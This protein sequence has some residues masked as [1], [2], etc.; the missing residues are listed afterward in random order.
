MSVK[1]FVCFGEVLMDQFPTG[2]TIGGSPLNVA[3]WL[4][5]MDQNVSM[6]SGIGADEDGKLL[7]NYLAHN[8]INTEHVN[9][10]KHLPTGVV[11]VCIDF[12]GSAKYKIPHPVAWDRIPLQEK[13]IELVK[14]SDAF[15]YS[16]LPARDEVNFSTIMQLLESSNYNILDTNLR[17]PHYTEKVLTSFCEAADFIKFNDEELFEIAKIYG[18]KHRSIE[19]NL[20]FLQN[21][22]GAETI[23][24]TK[25]KY[26]AVVLHNGELTYFSGY[27]AD[28]V[29]TVGAGDSFLA[30]FISK[31]LNG[32]DVISSLKFA[33]GVGAFVASN[34][35]ANPDI[36]N[37]ELEEFIKKL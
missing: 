7:M 26:G 19:D 11:E 37:G 9:E 36:S 3:V 24:V 28:V 12:E 17:A 29:D 16:S 30:C 13:H 10:H 8:G 25:G 2:K 4:S 5:K 21:K 31:F 15:C 18:S 32:A 14:N 1:S 35:G 27:L 20:D 22:S 33:C 23:C 34:R 6:I